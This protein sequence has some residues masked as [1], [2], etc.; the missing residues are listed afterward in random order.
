MRSILGFTLFLALAAGAAMADPLS[1][2]EARRI[3]FSP[4]RAVL[5]MV[6]GHGLGTAEVT[7]LGLVTKKHKY[8][9]AVAISPD[10]GLLSPATF[11]ATN[12]H[13]PAAAQ[14][15]AEATCNANRQ[16]AAAPCRVVAFILPRAYKPAA[17]SLSQD[18]TKA[19]RRKWPR[20]DRPGVLA[21]SPA[22]VAWAIAKGP[23]AETAAVAR[24]NEL[25]GL[26]G[27]QDCLILIK[28]D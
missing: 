9:G 4:N 16:E 22:T 21:F 8:Y 2:S 5:E 27:K 19:L 20:R 14:A 1:P 11:A 15:L 6:E 3:L 17:V 28:E 26:P 18:A 12:M 7:A 10:E 25:A 23:G 24:C 13:G